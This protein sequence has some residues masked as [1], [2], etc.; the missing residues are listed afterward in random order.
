MCNAARLTLIHLIIHIYLATLILQGT[1]PPVYGAS[2][3]GHL[4]IVELLFCRGARIDRPCDVRLILFCILYLRI[5]QSEPHIKHSY[6]K[7]IG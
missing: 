4:S 5:S 7:V 2:E 6:K 1:I 3:G